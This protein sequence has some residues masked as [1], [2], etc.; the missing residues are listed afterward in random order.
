MLREDN[1]PIYDV[2]CRH[3]NGSLPEQMVKHLIA[4]LDFISLHLFN[5]QVIS[6]DA[7]DLFIDDQVIHNIAMS[8]RSLRTLQLRYPPHKN[9]ETSF[10]T[11]DSLIYLATYGLE[12]E[13]L[14]L[15]LRYDGA[16]FP[17]RDPVPFRS[18]HELV[19]SININPTMRPEE[20]HRFIVAEI[21]GYIA[22]YTPTLRYFS[23]S[24]VDPSNHSTVSKPLAEAFSSRR[25]PQPAL[26]SRWY[27]ETQVLQ[28]WDLAWL[29]Q[30]GGEEEEVMK[31][32]GIEGW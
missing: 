11:V 15:Q 28:M 13:T 6:I 32:L 21:D 31:I 1:E 29:H 24:C 30:N 23:V 9:V 19:V 17:A 27:L 7:E 26:F 25:G 18:L 2:G 5:F 20:S 16:W 14:E 12:L 3:A 8:C 4:S 22:L 10:V